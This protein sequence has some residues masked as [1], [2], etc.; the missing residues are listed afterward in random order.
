MSRIFDDDVE[1]VKKELEASRTDFKKD[2]EKEAEK[3]TDPTDKNNFK[4]HATQID[5]L[6]T[7]F[8]ATLVKMGRILEKYKPKK[9]RTDENRTV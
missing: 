4:V 5:N 3:I 7:Q 8:G 1:E 9:E 6:W 2:F